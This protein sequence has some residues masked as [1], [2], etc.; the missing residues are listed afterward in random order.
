M[1]YGKS[2]CPQASGRIARERMDEGSAAQVL[3]QLRKRVDRVDPRPSPDWP[4]RVVAWNEHLPHSA[5]G[6][7][8]HRE[9]AGG[10]AHAAI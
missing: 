8:H 2:G 3:D 6:Q 10:V 5:L 9:H 7:R 1:S 4:R